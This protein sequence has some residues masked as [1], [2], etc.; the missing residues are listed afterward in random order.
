MNYL[1]CKLLYFDRAPTPLKHTPNRAYNQSIQ[2]TQQKPR[3][4]L[5]PVFINPKDPLPFTY[6]VKEHLWLRGI[7]GYVTQQPGILGE[8]GPNVAIRG[9][10]P[11]W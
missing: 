1:S 11:G 7:A 3:H 8:R 10:D 9:S 5:E 6:S 4:A 2:K